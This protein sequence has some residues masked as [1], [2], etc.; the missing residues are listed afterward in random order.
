MTKSNLRLAVIL[1][2]LFTGA[3]HLVI[4]NISEFSVLFALNGAAYLILLA[5][6]MGYIKPLAS[7]VE[8]VHYGLMGLAL[9]T[10]VA[11]FAVWGFPGFSPLGYITKAA[12][13]LLIA[14]TYLHLKKV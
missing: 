4:L 5:A 14:T 1:L 8:L 2:T 11:Y 13:V 3:V 9:A 6:F 10:I 7:R 12:E